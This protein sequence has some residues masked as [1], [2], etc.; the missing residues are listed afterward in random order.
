M[1]NG[2]VV[3]KHLVV[4]YAEACPGS[5]MALLGY[6]QVRIGHVGYV[7]CKDSTHTVKIRARKSLATYYVACHRSGLCTVESIQLS[8]MSCRESRA[9]CHAILPAT[10]R[11]R[12]AP[13]KKSRMTDILSRV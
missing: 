7:V 12:P 8:Q 4:E 5:K 2:T 10:V 3:L 6:L 9:H 1:A 13:R 11:A